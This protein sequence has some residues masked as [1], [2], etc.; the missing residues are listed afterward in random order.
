M[1]AELEPTDGTTDYLELVLST[2][3]DKCIV[4]RKDHQVLIID[5]SNKNSPFVMKK[6]KSEMGPCL[7]FNWHK[8]DEFIL[9]GA[10]SK[11]VGHFD[12]KK[13]AAEYISGH[14]TAR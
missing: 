3:Q 11:N 9:F 2:H 10:T 5:I 13:G 6:W 8:D 4:S 14:T 12:V 1:L 7:S